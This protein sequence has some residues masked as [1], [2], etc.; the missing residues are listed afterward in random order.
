MD[1][2][3]RYRSVLSAT[4]IYVVYGLERAR[5]PSSGGIQLILMD[6]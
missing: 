2:P 5:L 1:F 3:Y 6:V 4:V